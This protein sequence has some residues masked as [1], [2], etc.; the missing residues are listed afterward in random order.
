[1]IIIIIIIRIKN[2]FE[3][4]NNKDSSTMMMM[5]FNIFGWENHFYINFENKD[6]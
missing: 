3:F 4:Q 2:G 6:F 1:M 5:H